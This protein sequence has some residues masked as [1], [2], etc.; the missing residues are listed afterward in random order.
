MKSV[1]S[2]MRKIQSLKKKKKQLP[3]LKLLVVTVTM[4]FFAT[5]KYGT[6]I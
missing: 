3:S 1:A 4:Q 6:N 2:E 5:H